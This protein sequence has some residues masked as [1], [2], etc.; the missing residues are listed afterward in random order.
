MASTKEIEP[1]IT[2]KPEPHISEQDA[3]VTYTL[4]KSHGHDFAQG[5]DAAGQKRLNRKLYWGLV[6]LLVVIDLVLFIDKATLSYS[7][8]LGLFE[9]TKIGN[10][11]YNNLNTIFYAG[12]IIGQFPGN[13]LMQRVPMG[14]FVSGTIM[15][16]SVIVFLHCTASSYGGLIP[17]RFFLGLVEAT[18]LPAIE[19]TMGMFFVPEAQGFL[20]PV[21]YTSCLGSPIPA[22]F[23]AY[24]LL[25]TNNAVSPWKFFMIIT[26]GMTSILAI[27]SWFYYP[28]NPAEARFLTLQEKL[29]LVNKVHEASH[30]SIENKKFKKSQLIESLR[31][32]ISWLFGLQAFTLMLSNNIAYQSN[33]LYVSVGVSN[34]G[35]TL[36]S[37]AGGGFSVICCILATLLLR[38]VPW[39]KAYW[40]AF[41][42]LPPIAG[43][44][45]MVA[46][47][48]DKKISLL[49]CLVLAGATFG[50][51]YIIALGWTTSTAAGYTKKLS[52]N[53]FFMAGYGIANLVSPQLWVPKDAPR[54][55]PAWIIQ[56]VI[57]W[58][59]TPV[60]LIIINFIL[61]RRNKE[62]YA[63]IAEQEAAGK[64]R[65]G[66][67]ERIDADGKR[68][69]V[70]VDI[71]LLDLTDLEN[72]YFI[73]PL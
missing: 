58:V 59:G 7:S 50:I 28:N 68:V 10:G 18:V 22:G 47:D 19:I 30:S 33:L 70:E 32:P 53:V 15:L 51:T 55:Y 71:A 43:G 44:I 11:Q 1:R 61:A 46:L 39:R 73:Y 49:A 21:F 42:C 16:W 3:D 45:G 38:Y 12:Y 35:S 63:W 8:I 40:A 4:L 48:W 20:Q 65:T 26:G 62:R 67:I 57:S 24:G 64:S 25:W 27:L 69:E 9:D 72:K 29:Y 2:E 37:A 13:Y 23:L 60:I 14:K 6:P 52:R 56:I 34:L 5:L 41:W 31:D 66:V 54:Y 17:L 36:V